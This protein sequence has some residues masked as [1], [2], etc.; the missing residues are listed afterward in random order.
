MALKAKVVKFPRY[1]VVLV[2][3]TVFLAQGVVDE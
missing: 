1:H 3:K 2:K